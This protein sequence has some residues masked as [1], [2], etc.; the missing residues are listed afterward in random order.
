MEN[1]KTVNVIST[2]NIEG[3]I[4]S[5]FVQSNEVKIANGVFTSGYM[6]TQVNSCTGQIIS[7]NTYTTYGG[8]WFAI[9]FFGSLLMVILAA[10]MD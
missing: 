8:I 2:P 5:C 4:G 3:N 10:N 9:I 1:T 6:A 7:Q